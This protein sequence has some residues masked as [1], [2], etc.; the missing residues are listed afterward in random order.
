VSRPPRRFKSTKE[1]VGEIEASL[2]RLR[3]I[4]PTDVV[5]EV[6]VNGE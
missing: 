5:P 2:R 1:G 4:C 3:W 6:H